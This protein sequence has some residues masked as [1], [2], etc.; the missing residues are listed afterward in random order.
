L[1]S[2]GVAIGI[3]L[4]ILVTAVAFLLGARAA[5]SVQE[6]R[7]EDHETFTGRKGS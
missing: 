7:E 5:R 4:I 2:Y 6:F 3:L 1:S